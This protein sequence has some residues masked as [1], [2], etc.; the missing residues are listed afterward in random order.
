MA[1]KA[2][3]GLLLLQITPIQKRLKANSLPGVLYSETPSS[4]VPSDVGSPI[5]SNAGLWSRSPSNFGWPEP[6]RFRW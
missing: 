4:C 5:V 3:L 1:P 6:K 2:M